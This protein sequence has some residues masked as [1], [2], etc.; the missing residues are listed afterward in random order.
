MIFDTTAFGKSCYIL[1]KKF[2]MVVDFLSIRL[3]KLG[4]WLC[5]LQMDLAWQVM[6]N[7]T[8]NN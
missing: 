7:A 3:T 8:G 1:S 5:R 2:R 4:G 6:L